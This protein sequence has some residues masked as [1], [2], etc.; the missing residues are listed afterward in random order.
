[1]FS[2]TVCMENFTC[3]NVHNFS[4]HSEVICTIVIIL[5]H[6]EFVSPNNFT[7]VLFYSFFQEELEKIEANQRQQ[8]KKPVTKIKKEDEIPF[9]VA[10]DD[11]DITNETVL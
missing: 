6:T 10:E 8:Y 7:Y 11:T 2:I 5:L 1:M 9:Y 3:S 4:L